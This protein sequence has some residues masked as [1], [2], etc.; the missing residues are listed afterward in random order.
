MK[1]EKNQR[2][3]KIICAISPIFA[4]ILVFFGFCAI[5]PVNFSAEE[6]QVSNEWGPP[7]RVPAPIN[8][9]EWEDGP[10]ISPDGKS[11]Y[12]TRGK[13]RDVKTYF[14]EKIA[15]EWS[16]PIPL[17]INM[18]SFPTGAPH[19]QDGRILYFSS[20]RPGG[21]GLA[22][23]YVSQNVNGKWKD[24][25]NLGK[26]INTKDMESEPFISFNNRELY[27]ASNR[28]GGKGNADI[29]MAEKGTNG[30][31]A[32]VN[33]GSSVNSESEETQPFVTQ[34]G[35][36]LYFTGI[37]RDGV[38]GPAIFRSVKKGEKWGE[39]QVVISGFVGEPTLTAD[40]KTLFFVHIIVKSGK[41]KDAEIMFTRRRNN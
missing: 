39:A 5:L 1:K 14:S 4:V 15:G 22:D 10:S 9:S 17:D 16:K 7:E 23:I 27:F 3:Q 31:N 26:A 38:P 2:K 18:E 8:S 34:D 41:L 19:T 37:N 35:K 12:F 11:L 28:R 21:I 24:V 40:R 30:W 29:W 6:I 25:K 20:I 13:D 36:E 33:L 32:P